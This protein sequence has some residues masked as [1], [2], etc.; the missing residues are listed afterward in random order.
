MLPA[1]SGKGSGSCS[2]T[3]DIVGNIDKIRVGKLLTFV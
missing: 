3:Y 1:Y 2:R